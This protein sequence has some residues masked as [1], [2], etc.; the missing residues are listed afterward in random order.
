MH[1]CI[2]DILDIHKTHACTVM[3]EVHEDIVQGYICTK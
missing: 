1:V 3:I 2:C